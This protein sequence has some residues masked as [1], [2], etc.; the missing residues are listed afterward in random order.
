MLDLPRRFLLH[1]NKATLGRKEMS[2]DLFPGPF[3]DQYSEERSL[4]G[5][6]DLRD[7]CLKSAIT[8]VDR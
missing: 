8:Q 5:E 1:S 2:G 3:V 6:G 7:K 4:K